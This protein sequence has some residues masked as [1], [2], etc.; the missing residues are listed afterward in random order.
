[1]MKKNTWLYFIILQIIFLSACGQNQI[2]NKDSVI[3]AQKNNTVV[4]MQ[5]YKELVQYYYSNEFDIKEAKNF[6]DS[7]NGYIADNDRIAVIKRTEDS[8]KIIKS[9]LSEIYRFKVPSGAGVAKKHEKFISDARLYEERAKNIIK[10]MK[11]NGNNLEWSENVHYLTDA[12]RLLSLSAVELLNQINM[13][14]SEQ[15]KESPSKFNV[16]ESDNQGEIVDEAGLSNNNYQNEN[17]KFSI[18][19]PDALQNKFT[20]SEGN[21]SKD[22]EKNIDF[23]YVIN[24]KEY[25]AFTIYIIKGEI[26]SSDWQHPFWQY[27]A[28][29]NGYTYV[30]GTPGELNAELVDGVHEKEKNEMIKLINYDVP[31]IVK[32]FK[33]AE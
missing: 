27:L 3:K 6:M 32:S 12:R 24:N 1:M 23:K 7:V 33:V 11:D 2:G 13:I 31:K 4:S 14:Q 19:F 9:K 21:W 28:M 17:Y 18:N 20:T 29:G 25:I 16:R 8:F 5:N 10:I 15:P 22:A 30:Y 26:Q